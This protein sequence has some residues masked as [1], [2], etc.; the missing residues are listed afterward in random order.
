MLGLGF[1]VVLVAVGLLQQALPQQF[2]F[3]ARELLGRVPVAVG[4][5]PQASARGAV[6]VALARLVGR[7]GL[8]K[9]LL[10]QFITVETVVTVFAR[11]LL[12][13][14]RMSVVAE[15][16]LSVVLLLQEP[17]SVVSVVAETP[18]M[19]SPEYLER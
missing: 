1:L 16:A 9:R 7:V 8:P 11:W 19:V 6:E 12:V 18:K 13:P 14:M 15:P 4:V 5:I 17:L 2:G 3:Q 10:L